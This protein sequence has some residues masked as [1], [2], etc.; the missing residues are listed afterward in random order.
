MPFL[1]RNIF[2]NVPDRLTNRKLNPYVDQMVDSAQSQS[3][4]IYYGPA[5]QG[6]AGQWKATFAKQ[7]AD[8]NNVVVEIGCHKGKALAQMADDHRDHGF[9]GLDITF[10]RVVLSAKKAQEHG[11]NNT[12]LVLGDARFLADLFAPQELTGV[13]IFFPDP[14]S[15]KKSQLH[16]RLVDQEFCHGLGRL[17]APQGFFWLKTDCLQYHRDVAS[18]MEA[19]G[20]FSLSQQNSPLK[21][22]YPTSYELKFKEK[23][24][25][26]YQ[27]IWFRNLD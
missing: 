5:L 21:G 11:L 24:V 8:V 1:R 25:P 10:K 15:K 3:L 14:W 13:A 19:T 7:S 26:T 17:L 4:P 23:N 27:Q 22:V 2:D 18:Y 16:N 12:A 20:L 9:V 6:K